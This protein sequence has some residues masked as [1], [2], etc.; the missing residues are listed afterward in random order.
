MQANQGTPNN[1]I[2]I[3]P[4]GRATVPLRRSTR[5]TRVQN[6]AA[7]VN[8]DSQPAELGIQSPPLGSNSRRRVAAIRSKQPTQDADYDGHSSSTD[9][10]DS[11]D[12]E[13]LEEL[14]EDEQPADAVDMLAQLADA[15]MQDDQQHKRG[16]GKDKYTD[17]R[18]G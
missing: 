10:G 17:A 13:E 11:S 7:L 5:V 18:Y 15:A 1:S 12:D 6:Y 2:N 8:D 3:S 4:T 14:S 16:R 9:E